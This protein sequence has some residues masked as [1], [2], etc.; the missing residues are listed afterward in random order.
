MNGKNS[1]QLSC[2]NMKH[3]MDITGWLPDTHLHCAEL[4]EATPQQAVRKYGQTTVSKPG[5]S[6]SRHC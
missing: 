2:I 5:Q 6:A 1:E 4:A 3:I